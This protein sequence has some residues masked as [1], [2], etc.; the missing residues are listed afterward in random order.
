MFKFL[1]AAFLLTAAAAV[2]TEVEKS[3]SCGIPG[4]AEHV[5]AWYE[6]KQK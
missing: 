3:T 6:Q 2:T 1:M 5:C 4:Y